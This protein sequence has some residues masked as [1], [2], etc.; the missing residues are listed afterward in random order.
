MTDVQVKIVHASGQCRSENSDRLPLKMTSGS[1][2]LDGTA[3]VASLEVYFISASSTTF[4]LTITGA[5][6]SVIPYVGDVA[7]IWPSSVPPVEPDPNSPASGGCVW[8]RSGNVITFIF[9]AP[10]LD[11]DGEWQLSTQGPSVPLNVKVKRRGSAQT[12]ACDSWS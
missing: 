7:F 8:S 2:L 1:T 12:G 3:E 6:A 5:S 4:T 10:N 11:K 9:H